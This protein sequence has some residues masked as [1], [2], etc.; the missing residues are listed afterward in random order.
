MLCVQTAIAG[1]ANLEA[2]SLLGSVRASVDA[3]DVTFGK[4]I[5]SAAHIWFVLRAGNE[6]EGGGYG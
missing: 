6:A 4:G 2:V 5:G 1:D 3:F